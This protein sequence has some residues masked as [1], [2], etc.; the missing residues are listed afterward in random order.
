MTTPLIKQPDYIEAPLVHLIDTDPAKLSPA[1]LQA[2]IA[3]V[4]EFRGNPATVKAATRTTKKDG[5]AKGTDL[6]ALL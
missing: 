5:S 3:Q 1:E 2:Y 6:S 4:R